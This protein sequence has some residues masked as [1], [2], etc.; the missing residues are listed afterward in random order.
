M[1]TSTARR[2]ALI[3]TR[4]ADSLAWM[5]PDLRLRLLPLG[6]AVLI[7]WLAGGRPSWLGL[8][9]GCLDVQLAAGLVGGVTLFLA[10]G[11]VQVALSGARGA[12]RVPASGGDAA[13]QAAYFTLNAPVE[14]AFFRGLVQGGLTALLGPPAGLVAGTAA[15]VLY[16]RL[17]RWSWLDVAATALAGVPLA[18]AYWLLPGPASLL[19]ISVAH[20]GATCGFLGP[21]PWLL[22][23]LRLL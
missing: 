8:A 22:R 18:L 16:H 11:L 12:V 13:L 19:G 5:G 10:A 14:E 23:R 9:A 4:P 20:V 6:A 7:A 17:G 21:G 2:P 1:A 3:P 15:Y